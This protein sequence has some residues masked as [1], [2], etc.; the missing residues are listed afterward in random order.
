VASLAT[1]TTV[2]AGRR[3]DG[4]GR[5]AAEAAIWRSAGK[6]FTH[7]RPRP[8]GGPVIT[9]GGWRPAGRGAAG[10]RGQQA[11]GDR[12][13]LPQRQHSALSTRTCRRRCDFVGREAERG[14]AATGGRAPGDADRPAAAARR[15]WRSRRRT[16]CLTP[17]GRRPSGERRRSPSGARAG[18]V[19]AALKAARGAGRSIETLVDHLRDRHLLLISTT[20]SIPA[21]CA[22]L[23]CCSTPARLTARHSR[24]VLGITGE[25]VRRVPLFPAGSQRP[26]SLDLLAGVGHPSLPRPRAC[27]ISLRVDERERRG[28]D[29][30]SGGGWR[31]SPWRSSWRRRGSTCSLSPRS[32]PGSTTASGC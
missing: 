15:G 23:A 12:E 18:A 19:V 5:G 17:G 2:S 22:A 28:G 4:P 32:P 27:S 21:A 14:G 8:A 9:P 30:T 3:G 13:R 7:L 26:P 6:G 1:R 11:A 16:G 29:G 31:A 24:T 20:A 10:R 25:V